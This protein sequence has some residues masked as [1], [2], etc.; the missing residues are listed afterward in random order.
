MSTLNLFAFHGNYVFVINFWFKTH[1]TKEH[2]FCVQDKLSF[3]GY[4][5]KLIN[6]ICMAVCLFPI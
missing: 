2:Y 5:C 3:D 6:S 4:K 1:C